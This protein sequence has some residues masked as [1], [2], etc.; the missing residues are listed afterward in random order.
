ML[1][2]TRNQDKVK[3]D[4][5]RQDEAHS[6]KKVSPDFGWKIC[7]VIL[8]RIRYMNFQ[9]TEKIQFTGSRSLLPL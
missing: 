9:K 3:W 7:R 4:K 2:M 6:G 5:T 8:S 1:K